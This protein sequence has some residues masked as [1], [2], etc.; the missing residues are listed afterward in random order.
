MPSNTSP[1]TILLLGE[2]MAGEGIGAGAVIPGNLLERDSGGTVSVHSVA[3]AVATPLFAREEDYV[4]GAIDTAFASGDRIPFWYG[5]S[6]DQY[7][8]WLAD[9]F[10]V[11][12]GAL[13]ESAGDGTLRPVTAAV[14]SGTT[15]FAYTAAGNAIAR[16]VEAV[17]TTGGATAAARI[18]VEVI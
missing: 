17:N 14:Q 8:A 3:G 12:I 13:L 10:N 18:K 15:P 1:K 5:R 7:Y 16:A 6:G 11:A 9:N 4:G 2:P